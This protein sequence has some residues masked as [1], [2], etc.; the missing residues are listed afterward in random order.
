MRS[1]VQ[2]HYGPSP[3]HVL[4]LAETDRPA[5]GDDEVLVRVQAASVDRGTWHLMTGR[6]ELMRIM[7]FGLRRPK[8]PNPGRSA[9]GTV[10]TVGRNVTEFV[11]GQEVY[12]TAEGSF[13]EY[14][15]AEVGRLAGKPATLTFAQAA[16]VP[17]SGVTALQAIRD[18]A[19]VRSGQTVLILGAS[20]GVGSFAVQIAKAFGAEVTGVC[21]T[22]K[23]ELVRRLGA[24]HVVDYTRDDFADG[25][26]SYDAIIDVGGNASLSRLRRALTRDGRLVIVGGETD[27]RWIGG[28]DR[29]LRALAL[30]P[31]V[32]QTLGLLGAKENAAD[33]AALGELLDSG[34]VTPAVDRTYPLGE[35]AAAVRYLMDGR[36][37]GKLVITV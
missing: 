7:G 14:A 35:T 20:G 32:T 33:L 27:G 26:C 34:Q 21:R 23:T 16:A 24:D 3:E 37:Q 1:I 9:A 22:A 10:E 36:T 2:E 30:S 4:R 13:A 17:V 28:F 12:G 18:R 6:P 29:Q 31:L 5:I 25:A 8:Q 15:R 19:R 11:A